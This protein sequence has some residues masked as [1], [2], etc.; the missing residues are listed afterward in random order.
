MYNKNFIIRNLGI[1]HWYYTYKKM[2][3]FN[4]TRSNQT[5]DEIWL[6]EHYPV[7]TQGKLSNIND[8]I[9][10]NHNIPIFCTD[11]GGKITYHAPGQQIMY[12]LINLKRR[13]LSIRFLINCLKQTIINIL[14]YFNIS[15]N[16]YFKD[17]SG[18]YI[19]NKK[20]ASIGIKIS[21]GC[22]LHGMSFNINM[23]LLPF[24]YIN[25]CGLKQLKMIN[26]QNYIYNVKIFKIRKFLVDEFL[27]LINN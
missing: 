5:L 12:I 18:I 23:N 8:I 4:Y 7:F 1:E 21:K 2:Y 6:V 11:R 16:S 27:F 15:S 10:Y 25:P 3:N 17:I 14:L 26:L 19:N 24:S 9:S 20:I 22:T 13:K